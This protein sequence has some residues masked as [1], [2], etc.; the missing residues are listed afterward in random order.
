MKKKS[1]SLKTRSFYANLSF[2]S[3]DGVALVTEK[4]AVKLP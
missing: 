4:E 3:P 2:L 1:Y